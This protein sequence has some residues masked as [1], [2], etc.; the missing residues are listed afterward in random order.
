MVPLQFRFE[1]AQ[2]EPFLIISM[3]QQHAVWDITKYY[4]QII[5][6]V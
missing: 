2:Q 3:T 4:N 5:R 6:H 1:Q